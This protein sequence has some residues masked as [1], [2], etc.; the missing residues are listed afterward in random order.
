MHAIKLTLLSVL[1]SAAAVLTPVSVPPAAASHTLGQ[2]LQVTPEVSVVPLSGVVTLKAQLFTELLGRKATADPLSAIV[3]NFEEVDVPADPSVLNDT[4]CTVPAGESTCSVTASSPT[5][6]DKTFRVWITGHKDSTENRLAN[7]TAADQATADCIT[8]E[9]GESEAAGCRASGDTEFVGA[10]AEPDF[11]DVVKASWMAGGVDVV[12][13]DQRLPPGGLATFTATA[14]DINGN[15]APGIAVYFEFFSLSVSD[16]D[17]NNPGPQPGGNPD[18]SCVTRSTGLAGAGTCSLGYSQ[19]KE[20]VDLLCVWTS[21]TPPVFA[22]TRDGGT[23]DAEGL[24]D[25]TANDGRPSPANDDQD[26]VRVVW[27]RAT[28]PPPPPPTGYWLAATDGGI[29]AFGDAEFKGSTGA[30]KLNQ[31]IV[32]M[33]GAP[34]N[35]GYWMVASDGGIFA[36]GDAR[37]HGSTGAIKLN[38]PMVGMDS[39]PSGNGYFLVARD[40]GIFAFGAA[41]FQGSTGAIKLNQPIVGMTVTPSGNGYWLVASDGGIFAFGDAK[42]FG[43]TGAIKLNQPIVGMAATPTG[44]GYWLVARDG[45]IFA[46]GDARFFGSTGAIK[47][48][49]PIVGMSRTATGLGY[50]LVASDGGIFA[51]GDARFVGSTGAIKLNKPIVAMDGF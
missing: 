20:G 28:A 7:T 18:G 21:A 41:R 37:F 33:A 49:Q 16:G 43:S 11:T 17:G 51:F 9:E 10:A 39:T 46:F 45:G 25:P 31:P 13:D 27:Q 35:K 4:T 32:G 24:A 6:V 26:V 34:A 2:F 29:F 23:C 47:L 38:Q 44:L 36:F 15:P 5:P 42:F 8:P 19:L 50:R 22:G 3:V 12:P 30:I 1:V 14:Y 48:N 40:G